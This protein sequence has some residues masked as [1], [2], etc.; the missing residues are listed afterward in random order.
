MKSLLLI[1]ATIISVQVTF[2]QSDS[3]YLDLGRLRVQKAFIQSTTIK[4]TDIA[5]MPFVNLSEVIRSWANGAFTQKD[6]MVYVVDGITVAD[7][8]A[9]NIQDIEDITIIRNAQVNQNGAGNLQL[10]VLVRTKQWTA[11]SKHFIFSAMG[12]AMSRKVITQLSSR[13]KESQQVFAGNFQQYTLSARGGNQTFN[14]G[15]SLGFIHDAL[16]GRNKKDSLFDTKTPGINRLKINLW[17]QVAINKNNT[18]SAYF[19]Y[20]PQVKTGD[21][22]V[23]SFYFNQKASTKNKDYLL[24]PYIK[25]ETKLPNGLLN[26]F[27]FSYVTGKQLDNIDLKGTQSDGRV[28]ISQTRDS[29]RAESFTFNDNFSFVKKIG[30]WLFEP[31]LNINFQKAFYHHANKLVSGYEQ[32]LTGIMYSWSTQQRW[33]KL[34]TATPSLS[35]SYR[36]L[37]LVQGGILQDISKLVDDKYTNT[38]SYPFVNGSV[39]L[40]RLIKTTP[41]F[42]WKLFGSWSE[43]FSAYDGAYQLR[44]FNHTYVLPGSLEAPIVFIGFP[45]IIPPVY[46]TATQRQVG[47]GLSL[48]EKKLRINYNYLNTEQRLLTIIELPI[49]SSGYSTII[50]TGKYLRKQHYISIEGDV[51][52]SNDL[53]WT[54]GLYFNHINNSSSYDNLNVNDPHNYKEHPSTG[55]FVNRIQYKNLYAGVDLVYLLNY[56]ENTTINFQPTVIKHNTLQVANVF[57]AYQFNFLRFND[58]ELFINVRNLVDSDTYPISPD[59]RKYFGG[60]FK[61]AL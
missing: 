37:F 39:N 49:P 35:V 1:I 10:M 17:A 7:I 25:L 44:D 32:D 8:D 57:I 2:A 27:T 42:D 60:G 9:Y 52:G 58:A 12:S 21:S 5:R 30:D 23:I 61:V 41:G 59:Y 55:G 28:F 15:G 38:R 26:K 18:L 54:S 40:T 22:Q 3:T 48:F 53:K 51:T 13:E 46:K 14:Y 43:R 56:K 29:L 11:D 36:S 19:N 31:T 50:A 20:V 33:G 45:S 6:Q 24:N 34:F 47:T 4:A 16:P